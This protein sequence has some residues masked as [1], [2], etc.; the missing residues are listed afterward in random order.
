MWVSEGRILETDRLATNFMHH[1]GVRTV[2][3]MLDPVAYG[4]DGL[5]EAVE[6]R[7]RSF[8]MGVQWH[9]EFFA[10]TRKMGVSFRLACA[11]SYSLAYCDGRCAWALPSQYQEGSRRKVVVDNGICRW[12][13]K[14]GRIYLGCRYLK[15]TRNKLTLSIKEI[16]I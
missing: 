15:E 10:G 6:V 9:P 12:Y 1:Q 7:D 11:G 4:P 2:A 5:V 3:P 13:L 14:D 8:I 16:P